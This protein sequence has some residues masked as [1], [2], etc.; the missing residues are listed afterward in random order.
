MNR[1]PKGQSLIRTTIHM[2]AALLAEL[3]AAGRARSL[4]RSAL[5]AQLVRD[6]MPK[7]KE[8]RA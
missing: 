3:D 4:S 7:M 8:G 1:Q 2:D 5:L 6:A